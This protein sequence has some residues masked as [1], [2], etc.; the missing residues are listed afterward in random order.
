[1]KASLCLNSTNRNFDYNLSSLKKNITEDGGAKNK[2]PNPLFCM[3]KITFYISI[4]I[5]F[6]I[7]PFETAIS[8]TL[9]ISSATNNSGSEL[10]LEQ[11]ELWE[12]LELIYNKL[13]V[14]LPD[15]TDAKADEA[16]MLFETANC[17]ENKQDY[18][19]SEALIAEADER[20]NRLGF[21]LNGYYIKRN[22]QSNINQDEDSRAY[23]ELSWDVLKGGYM[24]NS[25][26][27]ESLY[28]EA[29]LARLEGKSKQSTIKNKCLQYNQIKQFRKL[30]NTLYRLKLD[31]MEPVYN[32][33]RRAYFKGWS[34]LDDFLVA[35]EELFSTQRK[36]RY[37]SS[38]FPQKDTT[39]AIN[40]PV[41]D[42]D[43]QSIRLAMQSS[44]SVK[45][46]SD[47]QKEILDHKENPVTRNRL[48]FFVRNEFGDTS[49]SDSDRGV[50]AGLRFSI[51]L[52]K[53]SSTSVHFKK[54]AIEEGAQHLLL[55][56]S[57]KLENSY[58]SYHEQLE[59]VIKQQY[60]YIRSYERARRSFVEKRSLGDSELASAVIRLRTLLNSSIELVKAKHEL[61]QRLASVLSTAGVAY[62]N[63]YVYQASLKN[64]DYRAR[65]GNR[66]LYI[67]SSA[68]NTTNN[69]I[70]VDFLNTKGIHRVALSVG[71]KTN[72]EKARRFIK[73]SNKNRIQIEIITGSNS[74]IFPESYKQI[75]RSV[76]NAAGLTGA[77][78]LDIEPH[79][80]P[81]YKKQRGLYLK[82]Y[83][84]MLEIIRQELPDEKITVAVPH[85]WPESTYQ[86][87]NKLVDAVYIMAYG[88]NSIDT[89]EKR[90]KT[91]TDSIPTGK[92]ALI[93]RVDDFQ[94]EWEIEK[95]LE[96][97]GQRTGIRSF[98]LHQYKTFIRKV[99][100]K[101]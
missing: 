43:I 65:P 16:Y 84:K 22:I 81:G 88:T 83:L 87:I 73:L 17:S 86:K 91:I 49:T 46:L 1:M 36:L 79:T 24:E 37:L 62:D 20:N 32:I 58:Q 93:L 53:R 44:S 47:L 5:A 97:L 100:E 7:F 33:E 11:E 27:A 50:V 67:W 21:S 15:P 82:N 98:G 55:T 39:L 12:R 30:E 6:S 40:P 2:S 29:Q 54:L 94:D 35:E 96:Q 28:R 60:R 68:F 10:P 52:E 95:A 51:P 75:P 45:E 25:Q 76:I 71:K 89:I 69:E 57:V 59:R 26:Q 23:L 72:L 41:L 9:G 78:H 77:I 4:F 42:L 64:I 38:I 3:Q 99:G 61:Y 13:E 56:Q 8:G 70:L 18:M 74:W 14:S 19:R 90:I 66:L 34:Y 85:H 101:R 80:L 31:L 63:Q 48:R 92:I